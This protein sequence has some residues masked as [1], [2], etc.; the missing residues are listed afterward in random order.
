MGRSTTTFFSPTSS[1]LN[2]Q[3]QAHSSGYDSHQSLFSPGGKLT[4]DQRKNLSPAKD[5]SQGEAAP[6]FRSQFSPVPKQFTPERALDEHEK[7]V[8]AEAVVEDDLSSRQT[9]GPSDWVDDAK[10]DDATLPVRSHMSATP[11]SKTINDQID[12]ATLPSRSHLSSAPGTSKDHPSEVPVIQE[13]TEI[14]WVLPHSK[15]AQGSLSDHERPD[16]R[17]KVLD[18]AP[19]LSDPAI[20]ATFSSKPKEQDLDLLLSAIDCDAVFPSRSHLSSVPGTSRDHAIEVP[21]KEES[22]F[23]AGGC[24]LWDC[25]EFGG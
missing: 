4:G 13:S 7:I 24:M 20:Y 9:P 23:G 1:D 11:V 6:T 5:T 12:D 21:V 10:V 15:N 25:I 17:S 8:Q 2:R 16:S 14:G 22:V 18:L 3:N 19:T